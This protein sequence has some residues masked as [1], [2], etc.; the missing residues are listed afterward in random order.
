MAVRRCNAI[1]R[2][3]VIGVALGGVVLPVGSFTRD[4]NTIWNT[5]S[6]KVIIVIDD[7]E[8]RIVVSLCIQRISR[9]REYQTRETHPYREVGDDVPLLGSSLAGKVYLRRVRL[10]REPVRF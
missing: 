2:I 8:S 5:D 7:W 4:E 3:L 9:E 1:N 6:S 10:L